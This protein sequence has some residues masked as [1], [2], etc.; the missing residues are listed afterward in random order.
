MDVIGAGLGRTGTASLQI[1]LDTLGFGPCYHM[2]TLLAEPNRVD[3]WFETL[4]ELDAGRDPAWDRIFSGFR[5]AVDWPTAAFWYELMLRYPRAKVILTVRDAQQWF[6]SMSRTIA[7]ELGALPPPPDSDI[8]PAAALNPRPASLPLALSVIRQRVFGDRMQDRRHAIEV[9]DAHNNRVTATI[10]ASRLLV[11][12]VADGWEPLC[13]FLEVPVP[14]E[15][16]P[17]V[18]SVSEFWTMVGAEQRHRTL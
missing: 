4:S 3:H 6:D 9:F 1:A 5:A 12:D 13:R 15:P 8:V 11:F 2:K 10:P 17:R 14:P 18:N 7:V 16:F